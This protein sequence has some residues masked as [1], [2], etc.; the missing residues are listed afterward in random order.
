MPY[1]PA[2]ASQRRF[3]GPAGA[4]WL[5]P[6][7]IWLPSFNPCLF[8][9]TDTEFCSG[10]VLELA[11]SAAQGDVKLG[12]CAAVSWIAGILVNEIMRMVKNAQDFYAG[13]AGPFGLGSEEHHGRAVVSCLQE[14]VDVMEA[15]FAGRLRVIE[16]ER[17]LNGAVADDEI[18]VG[19]KPPVLAFDGPD[20][21]QTSGLT[22]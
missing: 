4:L 7:L 3:P 1:R 16:A 10:G 15:W 14:L 20:S 6:R 22:R 8:Q 17:I 9:A 13:V 12:P 11:H 19:L 21:I 18:S 2:N 5:A